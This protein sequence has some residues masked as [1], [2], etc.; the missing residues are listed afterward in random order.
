MT[1]VVPIPK[2]IEKL[3][4]IIQLEYGVNIVEI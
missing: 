2:A 4:F 3:L 1:E